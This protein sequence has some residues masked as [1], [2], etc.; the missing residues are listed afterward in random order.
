MDF[1]LKL[2]WYRNMNRYYDEILQIYQFQKQT[3]HHLHRE[4]GFEKWPKKLLFWR[5]IVHN[6]M[7]H[8][9]HNATNHLFR[10][11]DPGWINCLRLLW[12]CHEWL[13]KNDIKQALSIACLTKYRAHCRV[14]LHNNWP[15]DFVESNLN[16]VN[17]HESIK[18]DK[19]SL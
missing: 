10:I 2:P 3:L 6:A 19:K 13:A 9:R 12:I 8:W 17:N 14:L 5:I 4:I 18:L 11:S 15:D 7:N 16:F 1:D